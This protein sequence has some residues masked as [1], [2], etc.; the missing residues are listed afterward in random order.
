M[1]PLRTIRQKPATVE[2]EVHLQ[3]ADA[4]RANYALFARRARV[5]I[6][7]YIAVFAA[8][9]TLLLLGHRVPNRLLESAG[10]LSIALALLPVIPISYIYIS[11]RKSFREA[12]P[13]SWQM[14][15]HF[16]PS[17]LEANSA[18][19]SGWVAWDDLWEALETEASLLLFVSPG[20][21]YLIP[22]RF[23]HGPGELHSVRELLRQQLG[24]RAKLLP[25]PPL[26]ARP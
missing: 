9:I 25:D 3:P 26:R 11:T 10:N 22:K 20:H 14:R 2:L 16:C 1:T 19:A 12:A 24:A 6:V 21:H 8:A 23:F 17:G 4:L 5:A 13:S 7:V 18:T 15:Y